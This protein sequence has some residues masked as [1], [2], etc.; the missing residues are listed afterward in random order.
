M[1]CFWGACGHTEENKRWKACKNHT[2]P[3]ATPGKGPSPPKAT[4]ERQIRTTFTPPPRPLQPPPPPPLPPRHPWQPQQRPWR[5]GPS[6]VD[7]LE[8]FSG[9]RWQS[10]RGHQSSLGIGRSCAGRKQ[11]HHRGVMDGFRDG[12]DHRGA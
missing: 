11:R 12:C 8:R 7:H 9:R 3:I 10:A 6:P 1:P 4:V 5:Y 2:P